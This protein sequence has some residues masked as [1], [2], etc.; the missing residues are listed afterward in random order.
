MMKKG[1][2]L[3]VFDIAG[4]TVKDGG[5]IAIAF[6]KALDEFGYGVAVER[7]NPLMGYKKTEAIR[8]LL[9]EQEAGKEI[10]FGLVNAIHERFIELMVDHY[11]TSAN[12]DPLPHAESMFEWLKERGIRTGLD[13][14]FP[15]VIT[16]V[17]MSRLN[18]Q[19]RGL[20]NFVISSDEVKAGRPWPFMIQELM[21]RSLVEDP[22]NVIKVGDTEVDVQEGKNAGCLYSIG[23]TTGA[24]TKQQL[25][26]YEPSYII[27]DL[28]ELVPIIEAIHYAAVRN[29]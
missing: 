25:E 16:D 6:Q 18:W 7:I 12:I 26:P 4:T 28:E 21:Q 22:L 5:E 9:M 14:G 23:I 24:F 17:I 27:G 20:A 10:S 13:T 19:E 11:T 2:E 8:R 29:A 3:V 15:K 1:I